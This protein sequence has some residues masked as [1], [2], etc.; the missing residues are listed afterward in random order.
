[1][2]PFLPGAGSPI[3]RRCWLLGLTCI[4]A[5]SAA[6]T[7][8]FNWREIRSDSERFVVLLPSRPSSMSREVSLGEF[9][10]RMSMTGARA[11]EAMFTVGAA[12]LASDDAALR[13]QALQAMSVAML[14]NIGASDPASRERAV[15][16]L[17][18][19]GALRATQSARAIVAPGRVADRPV[20]MQA[21]FIGRADRVWQV[22]AIT[23][24]GQSDQGQMLL[25]SF[26]LIE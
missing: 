9:S 8:T 5:L 2:I 12:Q 7:P 23:A 14:R 13:E 24:P 18:S 4:T 20:L 11:D 19:G 1:M 22:V 15:Q 16:V 25:D 6:C 3:S 21:L 17:D 10:V 26:R